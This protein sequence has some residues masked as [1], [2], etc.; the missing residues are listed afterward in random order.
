M[1]KQQS[2]LSSMELFVTGYLCLVIDLIAKPG[3][4][5]IKYCAAI[6]ILASALDIAVVYFLVAGI[7]EWKNGAKLFDLTDTSVAVKPAFFCGFLLLAVAAGD[8]IATT[9]RFLRSASDW[10]LSFLVFLLITLAVAVY[11]SKLGVFSIARTAEVVLVLLIFSVVLIILS[12]LGRADLQNLKVSVD[13]A[14]EVLH[15]ALRGFSVSPSLF[16]WFVLVSQSGP[17]KQGLFFRVLLAVFCS[18]VVFT[19]VGELVLGGFALGQSQPFYTLARIGNLSVFRRLDSL[20]SFVWA[21]VL[22]QKLAVLFYTASLLLNGA[23]KKLTANAAM[24]ITAA[25][26]AVAAILLGRIKMQML[27]L[28]LTVATILVFLLASLRKGENPPS[29]S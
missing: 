8:T 19:L 23:V 14:G 9:F 16:A 6:T 15:A 25:A 12:T 17:Q 3:S 28:I 24:A 27:P 29:E 13:P 11:A 20:H 18:Y 22:V 26:C 10:Q 4:V 1:L 2:K 5:P 7:T 21:L